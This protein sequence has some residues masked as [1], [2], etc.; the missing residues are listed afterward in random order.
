MQRP[1]ERIVFAT[2]LQTAIQTA[3]GRFPAFATWQRIVGE[4]KQSTI[5]AEVC[6]MGEQDRHIIIRVKLK[7]SATAAE[8]RAASY[9]SDDTHLRAKDD[10]AK[11]IADFLLVS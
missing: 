2:R 9:E 7:R 3:T 4:K 5:S 1:A 11:T 10:I 8:V 6:D